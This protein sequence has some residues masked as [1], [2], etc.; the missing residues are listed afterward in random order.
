MAEPPFGL[1]YVIRIGDEFSPGLKSFIDQTK[2][3]TSAYDRLKKTMEGTG[4]GKAAESNRQVTQSTRELAAATDRA[5]G[6]IRRYEK[7]E[8]DLSNLER[9]ARRSIRT[10]DFNIARQQRVRQIEDTKERIAGINRE[11]KARR[12][13]FAAEEQVSKAIEKRIVQENKARI[14]KERGLQTDLKLRQSLG[15]L[16]DAE[17]ERLR[18]S[19]QVART[20]SLLGSQD[21]VRQQAELD[22]LKRI[23]AEERKRAFNRAAL[24]AGRADLV[25]RPRDLTPQLRAQER[26]ADALQKRAD[27]LAL[28]QQLQQQGLRQDI[29]L[30]KELGL[31]NAGQREQLRLKDQQ[32]KIERELR[33]SKRRLQDAE[34]RQSR[35]RIAAL[36]IINRELDQQALKEQLTALGRADLIPGRKREIIP[37]EEPAKIERTNRGLRELFRNI[38]SGE[39]GVNRIS[40]TF[41]RL[42]GILAAF[43]IARRGIQGLSQLIRSLVTTN[44]ELESVEVGLAGVISAVAEVRGIDGALLGVEDSFRAAQGEASRQLR[45][46]RVEAL[47]TVATFEELSEAFQTAIGPGLASGFNLDQVRAFTVQISQAAS[48]I[49]LAQN[50]LAEEI[51]SLLQG[52]INPRNTRIATVLNISNQDIRR[53]REAG[54][55]FEF[56]NDRLEAFGFAG[57]QAARTFNGL[58]RRIRDGL[59]LVARDGGRELF[60][61]LTDT[62]SDFLDSLL[63][64][65]ADTG[66]TFLNQDFVAIAAAL[67]S[68]LAQATREARAFVEA[69][70][71]GDLQ[72]FA[73][74]VGQTIR[75]L[76]LVGAG[77]VQGVL[78]GVRQI[79]IA[80]QGLGR[81]LRSIPL[82]GDLFDTGSLRTTIAFVTQLIVQWFALTTALVVARKALILLNGAFVVL[83]TLGIAVTITNIS[84]S[85]QATTT[86]ALAGTTATKGFAASLGLAARG[87]FLVVAPL[88]LIVGVLRDF[89]NVVDGVSQSRLVKNLLT[90][91]GALDKTG[92]RA[93]AFAKLV[94]GTI[95][96]AEFDQQVEEIERNFSR[97]IQ[98]LDSPNTLDAGETFAAA[99]IDPIRKLFSDLTGEISNLGDSFEGAFGPSEADKIESAAVGIFQGVSTAIVDALL[100]IDELDDAFRSAFGLAAR[101]A[102]IFGQDFANSIVNGFA[103]A[104]QRAEDFSR[105]LNRELEQSEKSLTKLSTEIETLFAAGGISDERRQAL[106]GQI[107]AEEERR[108]TLAVRI[109]D[110]RRTEIALAAV[111]LQNTIRQRNEEL[112]IA[113]L[114]SRI[115]IDGDAAILAAR[116]QNDVIA[117]RL[118]LVL[119]EA[120]LLRSEIDER[121]K[122]EEKAISALETQLRQVRS[123]RRETELQLAAQEEVTEEE[124]NSLKV[125]EQIEKQIALNIERTREESDLARESSQRQLI[126]LELQREILA[127]GQK[128]PGVFGAIVAAA[129]QIRGRF[130]IIRDLVQ[131]SIQGFADTISSAIADAFDPTT[132]ANIR[133]RFGQFLKQIGQQIIAELTRIAIASI[134]LNAATGGILGGVFGGLRFGAGDINGLGLNEGGK[135]GGAKHRKAQASPAH[136]GA[137]GFSDGGRPKGLHPT[138]T[139][140]AWLAEGEW[141]IRARSAMKAGHDAL[142]RLNAGAFD[143]VA[144]RAALGLSPS[145]RGRSP[146]VASRGRGFADGGQITSQAGGGAAQAQPAIAIIAPSEESVRRLFGGG[147]GRAA[148]LDIIGDNAGSIRGILGV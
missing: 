145:S 146:A 7:A 137:R 4:R 63:S 90:I 25:E 33:D 86:A 76:A 130:E 36:K 30:R 141:V 31:L 136:F 85:I 107:V 118:A 148:F 44:A 121:N 39:T 28:L 140:P 109:N 40:F 1:N 87:A 57:E 143:P 103:A 47:K 58:S 29:R 116:Q 128:A 147:G 88:L 92:Q 120:S 21:F 49:G 2:Q 61:E 67:G 134:I 69:L 79:T 96:Q 99:V 111:Q 129:E 41:R 97:L 91:E 122:G 89:E 18:V 60:E 113:S 131:S 9:K 55:L 102:N 68:S 73:G 34:T 59:Q 20:K 115:Q 117:E 144:L 13:Q 11:T 23:S 43:T 125:L 71:T 35:A 133:Q 81:V 54:T 93:E 100:R 142:A 94:V 84:K 66:E 14:V 37:E 12:L 106:L 135:V 139:I 46:L 123:L 127:A 82:I 26:L 42:F 101:E 105:S 112:R 110:I 16:S 50:Q 8:R 17:K 62:L 52:T 104:E 83:K 74:A 51:R 78:Q 126:N 24:Q 119:T 56:L 15:L 80:V 5:T 72:A 65:D 95:S 77:I 75:T 114:R 138:D 108:A 70:S 53:A 64:I 38:T 45:F 22:L 6:T 19:E 132:D 32:L 48:A 98:V 3:A 10:R 27:R 124:R